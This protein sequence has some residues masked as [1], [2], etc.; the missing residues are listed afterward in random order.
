MLDLNKKILNTIETKHITP[1]PRWQ[2]VLKNNTLWVLVGIATLI[3]SFA[4]A[5]ILFILTDNDWDIFRFLDKSI[6]ETILIAA[7]YIWIGVLI[8]ILGITEVSVLY[9]KNGYKYTKRFIGIISIVVSVVLGIGL[10]FI[11]FGNILHKKLVD[12]IPWYE[13]LVYTKQNEWYYPEK[14]LLS[15]TIATIGDNTFTIIAPDKSIW[16]I[17]TD[18]EVFEEE[19]LSVGLPVKLVGEQTGQK[20][21]EV[22]DIRLWND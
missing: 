2:F 19:D 13:N 10:Y 4:C 16:I 6:L 5:V 20:T 8:L 11:G 7:P 14:G 18:A 17:T 9:T 22:D 21:F 3:G 1:K 15:G 12:Q